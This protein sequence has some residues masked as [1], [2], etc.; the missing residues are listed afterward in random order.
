VGRRSLF[1]LFAET[2]L[3]ARRRYRS[4][5]PWYIMTSPGNHQETVAYFQDHGHFGL[6][7]ADVCFFS[8]GR[9]PV[10]DFSGRLL[11]DQKDRLSFAP[12]GHGGALP[13]LRRSGALEDLQRRGVEVLSYFQIDNPLVKPFDPLFIGLHVMSGSQMSTKVA[14]KV[15]DHERVGNVCLR[16][17]RLTIIEYS[18]FPQSCA[19]ARDPAGRREFDAGNLAIHLFDVEFIRQITATPLSLPVRRAEKGVA[20]VDQRG[21]RIEPTLPNAVKLETFIFDVLPSARNPLLL[22][23]DRAEEFSPVKNLTG[24]D[25]LNTSQCDQI[26]RACRWLEAAGIPVPRTPGGEPDVVVA[27]SPLLALDDAELKT[28]ASQIA[29]PPRGAALYLE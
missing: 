23:V 26:R 12:D 28:K 17:G 9:L 25:S 24:V 7:T 6:P 16:D 14:R 18:D 13:A 22:E 20:Y 1:H 21:L 15:D 27:I 3:A 8:Q 29:A 11:L 5:I 10:F 4:S 2:V 19:Q